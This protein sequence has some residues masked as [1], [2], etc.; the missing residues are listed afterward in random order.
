M[1]I[2]NYCPQTIFIDFVTAH[3]LSGNI[4]MIFERSSKLIVLTKSCT[5]RNSFM[6]KG[7]ASGWDHGDQGHTRKTNDPKFG[8]SI[9]PAFTRLFFVTWHWDDIVFTARVLEM[10]WKSGVQSLAHS[11]IF[12][13]VFSLINR[14]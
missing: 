13:L 4:Q 5:L 8:G 3:T 6:S 2:F 7:C 11:V 14:E 12:F 1:Y 9:P 10:I